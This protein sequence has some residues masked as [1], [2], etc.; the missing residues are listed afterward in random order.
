MFLHAQIEKVRLFTRGN[1]SLSSSTVQTSD[2][3]NCRA[4]GQSNCMGQRAWVRRLGVGARV[5][6]F[7][8]CQLEARHINAYV[9]PVRRRFLKN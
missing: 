2:L 3:I 9:F 5:V 1:G 8:F 7:P 6:F 4:A